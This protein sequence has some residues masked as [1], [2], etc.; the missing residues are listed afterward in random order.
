METPTPHGIQQ[1]Y[2]DIKAFAQKHNFAV[3]IPIS[4]PRHR[5]SSSTDH[6]KYQEHLEMVGNLLG[7]M[8]HNIE[9]RCEGAYDTRLLRVH[10]ILEEMSELV[11][12]MVNYDEE[13]MLDALADLVYVVVGTAVSYD[14]PIAEAFAEVQR[15]NMT[16]AVRKPGDLRLRDKGS[17]YSPPNMKAIL[18]AHRAASKCG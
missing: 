6:V 15:S 5:R 18:E 4:D 11:H 16:K 10:L 14:L 1:A 17:E 12:G 7:W 3:E 13:E 2:D 9:K 8:S